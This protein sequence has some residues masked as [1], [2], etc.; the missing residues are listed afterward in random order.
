MDFQEFAEKFVSSINEHF[1]GVVSVST[2][3]NLI[4]F[5]VNGKE[6]LVDSTGV[7]VGASAVGLS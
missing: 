2:S 5:T 4:V 3:E 7:V 1:S 6:I